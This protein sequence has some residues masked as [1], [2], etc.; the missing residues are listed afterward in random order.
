MAAR[1]FK[2]VGLNTQRIIATG[3]NLPLLIYSSSIASNTTGG[4]SDNNL[5]TDVGID[6]FLFVSGSKGSKDTADRG[7]TLFG[8]DVVISGTL[9]AES[10]VIEVDKS[11]AGDFVVNR[12]DSGN[13]VNTLFTKG[14]TNLVGFH[15]DNSTGYSQDKTDINFYVS[16]SIDGKDSSSD[17]GVAV[18]GGDVVISGT[19]Y[20]ANGSEISGNGSGSGLIGAAEDNNYSD[21]LFTDF[22]TTTPIGTAIDR[23]NEVLKSLA[24]KPTPSLDQFSVATA[25]GI[26]A[27][28]SFG[29]SS[30]VADYTSVT[31]VD[32]NDE[33]A[34]GIIG[35]TNRLGIYDGTQNFSGVLNND[36]ALNDYDSG[37]V[38][39]P[40]NS[41][42]NAA[43]GSLKLF[44]N[45]VEAHSL[46]LGLFAGAGEP[47]NGSGSDLNADGSGFFNMSTASP[48]SFSNGDSFNTFK[49][50]TG[51]WIVNA[52]SQRN[53]WNY[54]QVK[55]VIDES[56]TITG[57]AEWV[58]DDNSNA[59]TITG[60]TL[61]ANMAGSI[62]L[63]GIQYF[64][65]GSVTYIGTVN[66][67]Y[68]NIYDTNPITFAT[69]T[70]DGTFTLDSINKSSINVLSED[71]TKTITLGQT[72]ILDTDKMIGGTV[73]A[74]VTVTHPFTTKNLTNGGAIS[75]TNDILLYDVTDTATNTNETFQSEAFRLTN[76]NFGFQADVTDPL[77]QWTPSGGIHIGI[78]QG[79]SLMVFDEKLVSPLNSFN[80][81]DFRN[82]DDGGT[83]E[84]GP[85]S[86]PDYS[87]LSGERTYIRKFQNNTG[88]II[89][90]L[91]YRLEGNGTL[92]D[93]S[94]SYNGDKFKLFFKLPD[95]G[96]DSTGWMDAATAFT[97]HSTNDDDGCA[98]GSIDTSTTLS[99]VVT[100]GTS[101]VA[102]GEYIV[103]KIA[104]DSSWTGDISRFLVSF[105]AV[106]DI[107][108]APD[109]SEIDA[110][111][112]GASGKLSFGSSLT[113]SGYTNVG[114]IQGGYA[115][116]DA[117]DSFSTSLN[118]RGIFDG[119]QDISGPI[120]D[121]V[122]SPLGAPDNYSDNAFGDGNQGTLK[123]E[124]N[125]VVVH[126]IDLSTFGSGNDLN[127]NG[128]GFTGITAA[129]VGLD[130]E[131]LPDYTKF[132]RTGNF[133]VDTLDQVNGW[134][135]ARVIHTID[136][137]D[138]ETNYIEWVNDNSSIDITFSDLSVHSV[139]AGTAGT[140]SLSGVEYFK[141]PE[142]IFSF[143]ASNVYKYVYSD[144]NNAISY[145]TT[146][147]STIT[148][149]AFSGDGITDSSINSS[150]SPLPSLLTSVSDS[151]D[152]DL[153]LSGT[154]SFDQA[155]SLP[156]V[157]THAATIS[158]RISHPLNGQFTT[159]SS[160]SSDML[161]YS[162]DTAAQSE[163][164]EDF[165]NESRR[166]P[167]DV[168]Y[169]EQSDVT[170][171]TWDSTLDLVDGLMVYNDKLIY[172][173]GNFK[174]NG[175]SGAS[176]N[177]HAPAG[178]PDYS[179]ASGTKYFY[180]RFQN[181]TSS[182][183]TGFT[184]T[185]GGNGSTLVSTNGTL[186]ATN[187][188]VSAKIPHDSSEQSTGFL[189]IAKDFETGQYN[190]GDG[191]LNG[192]LDA[193]ISSGNDS[194][195]TITFGQKFVLANEYIILKIEADQNWTGYIDSIDINWG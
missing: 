52:A 37:E 186:S 58:N 69:T 99:N 185:I 2:A 53:G 41:F 45:G 48:G 127:G 17:R 26:T 168:S 54:V 128:S 62:Y 107:D 158:G 40:A 179:T 85:A 124:V 89:R 178:N 171:N 21:G 18:F 172:P 92:I 96:T 98:I 104:A 194:V 153:I 50:R 190:D 83:I 131:L 63:S 121:S 6:T 130:D 42:G 24:P 161:V 46:D 27:N 116:K 11:V 51:E 188:K 174:N 61:T 93:S 88:G 56:E 70:S 117:N 73:T 122:S 145:P 106:G 13:S 126:T 15:D 86:N 95:N 33:F 8:G 64:T 72:G 31:G 67:A 180:R 5:T 79:F 110:T 134:N 30:E 184:L 49:H 118:R 142:G 139:T 165:S 144:D 177:L 44:I 16:G 157:A 133:I 192:V 9:Y 1:D 182:S 163:I 113:K 170:S 100:F 94:D 175:E 119:S 22:S 66:N 23:F 147:N 59:I 129:T 109:V 90:D 176:G 74:N 55:H 160:S 12:L 78:G 151:Y 112:S 125:G 149:I 102:D 159:N 7:V 166:L 152:D 181:T 65:A 36:V 162:V 138:R 80:G 43:T 77:Y 115:A 76:S 71:N 60:N 183:Q 111:Q 39:Y 19:L 137:D 20:D 132:Y 193:T 3:S 140:N 191:S 47:G 57:L 141:S 75:L 29:A 10:Q 146:D 164:S 150:V 32:V 4:V 91:S 103:A 87:N 154:F 156:N 148:S 114:S 101:S 28:L 173:E 25:N 14:D 123:L 38:N 136:T 195:N 120:N 187:I 105:G 35:S 167:D 81:G 135:Y 34:P 97:Y 189:N 68:R 82:K 155:S 84:Y 108:S 169:T 143:V